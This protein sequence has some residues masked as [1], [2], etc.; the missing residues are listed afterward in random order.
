MLWYIVAAALAAVPVAAMARR[1][2]SP[3]RHDDPNFR[4]VTVDRM[5]DRMEY[6]A[7]GEHLR[8]RHRH[9]SGGFRS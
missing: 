3:R 5:R 8:D 9:G 6:E 1:R 7:L 4:P 2:R